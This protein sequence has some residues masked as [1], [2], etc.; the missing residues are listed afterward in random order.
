MENYA[1]LQPM[2]PRHHHQILLLILTVVY[3]V[4]E[5]L[6]QSLGGVACGTWWRGIC[7]RVQTCKVSSLVSSGSLRTFCIDS[8]VRKDKTPSSN[9]SEDQA[10][11]H[12]TLMPQTTAKS[13]GQRTDYGE[14]VRTCTYRQTGSLSSSR[15]VCTK[16]NLFVVIPSSDLILFVVQSQVS[17]LSDP[18]AKVRNCPIKVPLVDCRSLENFL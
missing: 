17:Q 13:S 12:A 9:L 14:G 10:H 1:Q 4:Q 16:A 6:G 11:V 15:H 5:S 3:F 2:K 8:G 18:L 7:S